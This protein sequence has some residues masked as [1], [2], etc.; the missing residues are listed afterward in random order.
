MEKIFSGF[1]LMSFGCSAWTLNDLWSFLMNRWLYFVADVTANWL[2]SGAGNH[3]RTEIGR[4]LR[5]ELR[6][7]V[8]VVVVVDS[9]RELG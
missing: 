3:G 5:D 1:L 2:G 9:Y 7:T 4:R 6:P 8:V